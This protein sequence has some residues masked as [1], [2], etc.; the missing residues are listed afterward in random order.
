MLCYLLRWKNKVKGIVP[1]YLNVTS[2]SIC[3]CECGKKFTIKGAP[4]HYSKACTV[5]NT[6]AE[7]TKHKADNY[8]RVVKYR[9]K[10]KSKVMTQKGEGTF[11]REG[12]EVSGEG[13]E[14]GG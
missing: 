12:G 3:Q 7:I 4:G 2:T 10:K 11:W 6:K 13:S 1:D 5:E 9:K 14:G 8:R